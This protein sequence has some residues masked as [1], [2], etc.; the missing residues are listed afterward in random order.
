MGTLVSQA[1]I[2]GWV[3]APGR[4]GEGPGVGYHPEK[5]AEI[6]YTKLKS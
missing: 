2:V 1:E 6:T 5:I 4:F 3:R